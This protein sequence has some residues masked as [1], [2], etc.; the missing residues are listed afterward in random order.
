MANNIGTLVG[1]PIRP[2]AQESVF[3]AAFADE[4]Q[5]GLHIVETDASRNGMPSWYL[6]DGMVVV[7]LTSAEAGN[8]LATYQYDSTAN[9][10]WGTFAGG[11]GSAA[12]SGAANGLQILSDGSIGLGGQLM[13]DTTI[14]ASNYVFQVGA[15]DF[16]WGN[17][18]YSSISIRSSQVYMDSGDPTIP[19]TRVYISLTSDGGFDLIFNNS[20]IT[21]N[22]DGKGLVYNQDYSATFDDRSLVDKAYVDSKNT[23][24]D[25]SI[26][27]LDSSVNSLINEFE[28]FDAS[29]DIASWVNTSTYYDASLAKR[30]SSITELYTTKSNKNATVYFRDTN[31]ALLSTDNGSIIEASGN[32]TITLPNSMA[33]GY[34]AVI[35]RVGGG[36]TSVNIVASGTLFSKD[37][38]THLRNQ[39]AGATV[40][41][42]G[43]NQWVAMGDL[44]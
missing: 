14:D 26:I 41:H 9:P 6:Q 3:A 28:F 24:Q 25:A 16:N 7:V 29:I 18:E 21:D 13:E 36:D 30:D 19:D 27:K 37:S 17:Q 10:S 43:S 38:S 4:L 33:T 2:F 1:A 12:V 39:W 40:Y 20:V 32:I 31:Y 5:G 42:R 44:N 22:G 35:V 11:G 15:G 8:A 34:Q 23:T